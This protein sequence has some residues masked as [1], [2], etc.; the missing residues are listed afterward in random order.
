MSEPHITTNNGWWRY[1]A[2][3]ASAMTGKRS[4][5]AQQRIAFGCNR[6]MSL[7]AMQAPSGMEL[8]AFVRRA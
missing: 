1:V 3:T 6:P 4:G 8:G 7:Q 5:G 2:R